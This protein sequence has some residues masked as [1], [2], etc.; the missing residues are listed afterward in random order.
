M[1]LSVQRHFRFQTLGVGHLPGCREFGYWLP[2]RGL[3][4]EGCV[5]CSSKDDHSG[6]TS[7]TLVTEKTNWL[8]ILKRN[9]LRRQLGFRQNFLQG[10]FWLSGIHG[11]L[12]RCPIKNSDDFI[13][14]PFDFV[15]ASSLCHLTAVVLR[16]Q[17]LRGMEEWLVCPGCM[18][19]VFWIRQKMKSYAETKGGGVVRKVQETSGC[20]EQLPL[21]VE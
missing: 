20:S 13:N 17:S 6:H 12:D 8:Q 4:A 11:L 19:P 16:L 5:W 15:F 1:A 21:W 14:R 9:F 3:C 18:V 2:S 10:S 7:W